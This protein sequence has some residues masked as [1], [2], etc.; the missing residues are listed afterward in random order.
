MKEKTFQTASGVIYYWVN[1]IDPVKENLVFLPGLTL[2]RS[3]FD[4]QLEYFNGKHN[5]LVWAPPVKAS[6]SPLFLTIV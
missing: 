6:Q 5:I 2:D 4:K 3:L 1:H